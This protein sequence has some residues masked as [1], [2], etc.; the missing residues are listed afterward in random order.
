MQAVLANGRIS[1]ITNVKNE[2]KSLFDKLNSA[3]TMTKGAIENNIV[4]YGES[5]IEYLI[6]KLIGSK[7]VQR[8]VAAMSLIRIGEEAI[9]PLK[10]LADADKS[11]EWVANYIIQEIKGTF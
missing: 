1:E 4:S 10:Q 11:V 9:K 3:D 2:L 7:G 8:G 6:D 5:A